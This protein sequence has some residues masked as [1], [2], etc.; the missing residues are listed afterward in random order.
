MAILDIFRK[1]GA[2]AGVVVLHGLP[3]RKMY[4]V[5]VTLFRVAEA[6]SPPPFDGDPPANKWSDTERVKEADDPDDKRLC[7][8]LNRTSGFYYLGIGVIAYLERNGQMFAQVERLF[9]LTKPCQIRPSIQ[10]Q[11]ESAVTWPDIPFD[12]LHTYGKVHPTRR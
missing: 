8:C 6:T 2:L 7:F 9:P 3:P 4:S 5:S 10:E 1:K 11:I 12:E